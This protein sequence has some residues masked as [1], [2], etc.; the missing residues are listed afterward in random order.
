MASATSYR[1]A[2]A[3]KAALSKRA[4]AEQVTETALVTRML[5]EGLKTADYPGIIYRSG[6]SGRRAGLAAGADVWEVILAMRSAEGSGEAKLADASEQLGV[7]VRLVRLAVD[8][9]TANAEEIEAEIARNDA[10][11]ERVRK[12]IAERERLL[13]S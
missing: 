11:A 8:F 4:E 7:P 10:A 6:P 13:A 5:Q 3:L 9:A 12:M 2:P 1:L